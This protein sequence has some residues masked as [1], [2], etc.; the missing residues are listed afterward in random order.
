MTKLLVHAYLHLKNKKKD[1]RLNG[2][3]LSSE[4]SEWVKLRQAWKKWNASCHPDDQIDWIEFL[5][6]HS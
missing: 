6:E 2:G 4:T 5:E 1:M 3:L